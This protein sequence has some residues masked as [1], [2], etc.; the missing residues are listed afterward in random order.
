MMYVHG[1]HDRQLI[2]LNKAGQPVGPSNDVMMELSS[3][4]GTLARNAT[5]CP[6]DIENWKLLD[7]K[8]DL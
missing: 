4:L 3:F 2:V 7:T 1:R 8:K 6:I 5:L